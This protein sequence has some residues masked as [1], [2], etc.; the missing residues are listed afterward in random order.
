MKGAS[1]MKRVGSV[2]L[3]CIAACLL[4]VSHATA[5]PR[6]GFAVLVGIEGSA[7]Y[8]NPDGK[9]AAHPGMALTP[10]NT[11]A[12]DADT[13]LCAVL[14]P[15]AILCVEEKSELVFKRLESVTEG[16]PGEGQAA[17][18][19]IDFEITR[20]AVLIKAGPADLNL[21]LRVDLRGSGAVLADGG[22]FVVSRDN[23][24][25]HV[26]IEEGVATFRGNTGETLLQTGDM[27]TVTDDDVDQRGRVSQVPADKL[28]HPFAVCRE[29]SKRLDYLILRIEEIGVGDAAHWLQQPMQLQYVGTPD[30]WFDVSPS[31]RVQVSSPRTGV[32]PAAP[33]PTGGRRGREWTWDWYRSVAGTIKGFNYLPRTAINPTEMWQAETF[34]PETIDEEFAWAT[35]SGHNSARV[36]LQYLVWKQDP[37]GFKA[38]MEKLLDLADKHELRVTFVLFNDTRT[39]GKDPYPGPQ[40]APVPGVFNSGWTP[41][42]GHA[43]V[44]DR[45]TWPDLKAYVQDVVES[46]RRDARVLMWDVYSK[47]GAY[48]LGK[49]AE[50]LVHEAFAWIHEVRP[51][52][53][54]TVGIWYGADYMTPALL[55]EEADIVTLHCY[56]DSE[57]LEAHLMLAETH[58]RPVICTEWLRRSKGNTFET[59][60]PI[61]AAHKVGWYHWGLV[62]GK[63]QFYL[64]RDSK[65]GSPTPEV[66][67]HDLLHEDGEPFDDKEVGF[68]RNFQFTK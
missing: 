15:G 9:G 53:P 34:D 49:Q 16:L 37:D 67:E 33:P 40:D 21:N 2:T 32:R 68:I 50:P 25:W 58:G 20:G 27:L 24:A 57:T 5:G 47:P 42:P 45:S 38:R 46:F 54:L 55:V 28:G 26:M 17:Q 51:T 30:V 62:Y 13:S 43:R 19:Y 63:S 10:G 12:T 39:A 59:V 6:I 60:L 48:G 66:W 52:Q 41:C 31:Q 65:P 8:R 36:F 14:T 11:L 7:N 3:T 35:Y 23:K 56:D 61:F 18:R 44:K 4:G 1:L 22:R 29:F 64:P